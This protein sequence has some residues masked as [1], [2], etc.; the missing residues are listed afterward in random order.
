M[1]VGGLVPQASHD[2]AEF[3]VRTAKT[4]TAAPDRPRAGAI[5]VRDGVCTVVGD[6]RDGPA[7][8]SGHVAGPAGG[9]LTR[10]VPHRASTAAEGARAPLTPGTAPEV[11]HVFDTTAGPVLRP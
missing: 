11:T 8:R 4:H 9:F 10:A 7:R 2:A 5:A 3:V 6:D 1:P